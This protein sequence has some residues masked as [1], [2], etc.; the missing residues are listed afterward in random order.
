MVSFFVSS[1][2]FFHSSEALL[3]DTSGAMVIPCTLMGVKGD[4]RFSFKGT[5]WKLLGVRDSGYCWV[6]RS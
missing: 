4:P 5:S 6:I 2:L 1:K 3:K